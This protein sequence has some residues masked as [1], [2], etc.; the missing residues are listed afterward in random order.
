VGWGNFAA[1]RGNAEE[2]A[3]TKHP[4]GTAHL[5]KDKFNGTFQYTYQDLSRIFV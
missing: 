1:N 2:A 3:T 5:R 4:P